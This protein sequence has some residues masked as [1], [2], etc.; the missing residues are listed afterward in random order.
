MC[1]GFRVFGVMMISVGVLH[2]VAAVNAPAQGL[3]PLGTNSVIE[4]DLQSKSVPFINLGWQ[5]HYIRKGDGRSGWTVQ[6]AQYQVIQDPNQWH[7]NSV[8]RAYL[9]FRVLAQMDNGEIFLS[10]VWN[11]SGKYGMWT[12][13][14]RTVVSFSKNGGETWSELRQIPD[15]Y[16][17]PDMLVYL[18][19][20]R[21]TFQCA[22]TSYF[23]N[24]YGRT[25]SD[26]IP[27]QR[28]T[29]GENFSM[30][31]N[32]LVE[33]DAQGNVKPVSYTHLRAHET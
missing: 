24:D 16:D 10:G 11:P 12:D 4:Y 22:E 32:P 7:T 8:G 19:G 28:A 23:S 21:L 9:Q 6:E 29:N 2:L 31:G 18:G 20:G 3:E 14:E 30:E 1:P 25:W 15:A 13:Q 17:R 27:T 5:P 33:R 26:R